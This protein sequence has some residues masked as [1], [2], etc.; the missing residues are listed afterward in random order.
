MNYILY[1]GSFRDSLLPFTFTRPVADLRIGI[2]T[3]RE[4]WET[5]LR[6]TTTT[7]TEEYLENKYPLVEMEFNVFINSGYLPNTDFIEEVKKLKPHQKIVC[8]KEVIAFYST[9]DQEEI[10]LDDY[11]TIYLKNVESLENKW[12][13]FLKNDV[14]IREDFKQ[15]THDRISEELPNYVQAVEKEQIF[16]EEG[17][18]INPCFLNASSGPIYIGKDAVILD[19]AMLRGPIA[20][21]EKAVVKMGAKIY[22]AT[23]IGPGCKVGGEIKNSILFANSNKGH[24]GYLGDSVVGEW[25]NFGADTNVSNLKNNYSNVRLW[26]Y[27]LES[28]EDTQQKNCGLMMGDHSKTGINTMFNTGT[29]LGVFVNIFGSHMP[30]KFVPSYSWGGTKNK[31]TY[32]FNK[33]IETATKV[34]NK[35]NQELSLEDV[36][37]LKEIFHQTEK[38]RHKNE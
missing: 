37:I 13:L 29:V 22:G 31:K 19:G 27:E 17:A 21:G 36:A 10:H 33:A 5:A 16:I 9:E 12:D 35:P 7:L 24:E 14:A 11:D 6:T 18:L 26:N 3:I 25:C 4:K 38:Y 20:L 1:D 8:N 15:I 2:L 32:D 23:T 34:I 30:D 28:F